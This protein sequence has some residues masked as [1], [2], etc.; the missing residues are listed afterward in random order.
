[1]RTVL[2]R[3]GDEPPSELRHI[4]G[5]GSTEVLEVSGDDGRA[6]QDADRVV[7]WNGQDVIVEDR[8]LRWPEDEDELRKALSIRPRASDEA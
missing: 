6:T 4:V 3:G 1:M 5:A 7:I 2:I 8:R